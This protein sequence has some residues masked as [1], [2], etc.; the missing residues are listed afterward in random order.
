MTLTTVRWLWHKGIFTF[1]PPFSRKEI[2]VCNRNLAFKVFLISNCFSIEFFFPFLCCFFN[3]NLCCHD[4]YIHPLFSQKKIWSP[5]K[6]PIMSGIS[7]RASCLAGEHSITEPT[8]L[9]CRKF[10]KTEIKIGLISLFAKQVGKARL[11]GYGQFLSWIERLATKNVTLA[12]CI[13][14]GWLSPGW[15]MQYNCLLG[16]YFCTSNM[17]SQPRYAKGVSD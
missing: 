2:Q 17:Q 4:P 13:K 11:Q 10:S 8:K 5:D 6:A 7:T 9:Q 14:G 3:L 15:N 16:Q 1:L 12:P